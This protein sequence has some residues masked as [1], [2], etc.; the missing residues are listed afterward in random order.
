[1]ST[2]ASA[3]PTSAAHVTAT[4]AAC[5][6]KTL[7]IDPTL[8]DGHLAL[9]RTYGVRYD[10]A[11]AEDE[12]REAI[13]LEPLNFLAWDL[14]SWVLAYKQPPDALEAEKA[15][16]EAIRLQPSLGSAQYHLG[17][18]LL[19]QKRYDE[20]TK[21]FER[22]EELGSVHYSE[23]GIAQVH[24]AQGDYDAALQI[25]R[26]GGEPTNAIKA[27]YLS[28]AYAA[29][30]DKNQALIELQ[31]TLNL[32]YRDFAAINASPYFDSLRSDPR[33]QQLIAKYQK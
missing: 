20:A 6:P 14:L 30:G 33:F 22:A 5:A 31:R 18:A 11:R 19:L 2:K 3:M 27:Y 4:V 24:M 17:R 13:R 7:A 15:A 12:F 25:L 32:G 1:M 28:A 8:P 21:A 23:E 29:K 16:R 26:S 10:Y 9:G